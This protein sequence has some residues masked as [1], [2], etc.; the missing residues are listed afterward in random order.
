VPASEI[1]DFSELG[2]NAAAKLVGQTG[3]VHLLPPVIF[4]EQ[5]IAAPQAVLSGLEIGLARDEAF[6]CIY[7]ANIRLLLAMG[8][9][10]IE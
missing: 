1:R 8:A 3:L 9:K 5:S 4:S 2:F 6:S 7:P 10:I